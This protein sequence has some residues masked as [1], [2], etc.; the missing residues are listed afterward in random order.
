MRDFVK[1]WV[2]D[3]TETLS[4]P[5]SPPFDTLFRFIG[6]SPERAF[7]QAFGGLQQPPPPDTTYDYGLPYPF[8]ILLNRDLIAQYLQAGNPVIE[9]DHVPTGGVFTL[10][11]N[12]A[13]SYLVNPYQN[14]RKQPVYPWNGRRKR[15]LKQIQSRQR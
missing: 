14:P 13:Q 3:V 10:L 4:Q 12:I 8:Y 9:Q 5:P 1:V 15:S 6:S 2:V 7:Q 11:L